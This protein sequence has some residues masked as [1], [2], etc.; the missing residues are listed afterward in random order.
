M[1]IYAQNHALE[2]TFKKRTTAL[3][4][5]STWCFEPPPLQASPNYDILSEG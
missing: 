4:D 5:F 3:G 1:K 2:K